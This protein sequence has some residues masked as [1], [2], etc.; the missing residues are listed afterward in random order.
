[1]DTDLVELVQVHQEETSQVA[2]GIPLAAEIQAVRIAEAKFGRQEDTAEGRFPI[3]LR[4]DE[5]RCRGIAVLLVASHP[6]CHHAQEPSVEQ[7]APM[8]M[9]TRHP[10]CQFADAVASVP[11]AQIKEVFLHGIIHGDVIGV[12]ESVDV[13]VPCL[14]AF[15][16]G[17]DG[18]AVS[19]PLVQGDE[20]ETDAVSFTVFQI[21]RHLV[22]TDFISALQ[23]FFQSQ[24]GV[25]LTGNGRP[26]AES[27]HFR[28]D[29]AEGGTQS[30]LVLAIGEMTHRAIYRLFLGD[31]RLETFFGQRSEQW[32]EVVASSPVLQ[33]VE[34]PSQG[35]LKHY[36]QGVVGIGCRL[37]AFQRIL[38]C[39]FLLTERCTVG[40]VSRLFHAEGYGIGMIM[41]RFVHRHA[42]ALS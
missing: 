26:C 14:D 6:V 41:R 19:C 20:T 39:Q 40:Q 33:C 10:V 34:C 5:H 38:L 8:G 9:V 16:Q 7:V 12:Q 17:L 22:V 2:F 21:V 11:F 15:F 37:H 36:R 35:C 29:I 1:M 30:G 27:L 25:L 23:E 42:E 4:T 31:A 18:D 3:P 28:I 24:G 32:S 13:P